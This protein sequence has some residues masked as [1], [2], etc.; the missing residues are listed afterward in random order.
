MSVIK[1]LVADDEALARKRITGFLSES[2]K[3]LI[4]SEASN[5]KETLRILNEDLPDLVFLDIKM[6]DMTGFDVLKELPEERTPVIIFVTAFNAFAVQAFEVQAI[7][8]LLKPYRKERF[9]ESLERGIRQVQLNDQ[10]E[11]RN[12]LNGLVAL[13]SGNPEMYDDPSSRYLKQIVLKKKKRYYFVKVEDIKFITS[14]GYYAEIFTRSDEKHIYRISM[15]ELAAN[16]DPEH[17]SRINRSTIISRDHVK[18]V[19]SEGMGDYS[20]VTTDGT[21]FALTKNYRTAFLQKIGIK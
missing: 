16:L 4:V 13:M 19:V 3:D 21:S 2:D 5:G 17:F 7:D 20:V 12:K 9:F 8:F 18:E 15:T 11:L 1:V 6:T 10:A 14:S